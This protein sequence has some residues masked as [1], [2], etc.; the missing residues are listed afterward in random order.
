M[1]HNP[2]DVVS[3]DTIFPMVPTR[4][5]VISGQVIISLYLCK[6]LVINNN[7]I[8]ATYQVKIRV[9][10]AGGE[11]EEFEDVISQEKY[12]YYS[13]GGQGGERL[14]RMAE[15]RDYK[16]RKVSMVTMTVLNVNY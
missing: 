6:K 11:S 3:V 12:S 13:D 10:Y 1:Y 15:E 8:M 2:T 16:G 4:P 9:S 5:K 14:N 7:K